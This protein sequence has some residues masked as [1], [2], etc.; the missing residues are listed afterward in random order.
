MTF[1]VRMALR[2]VRASWRRLLFFFLCIA[3]GVGSIAALRSVIQNVRAVLVAQA[4]TLLASDLLISSRQPFDDR[5]RAAIDAR[6]DAHGVEARTES[7]ET[8]TMARPADT[9]KETARMVELRGVEPQFPFYG[10]LVLE[11]G[12]PYTPALLEGHGA[13]VRPELLTQLG[14]SVGEAIVIGDTSFTVRGTIENE[15]GRRVGGFSLGPRVLVAHQALVDSGILTFGSRARYQIMAR[16]DDDAR[17]A[18][19]LERLREDFSDEFISARSYR[20][21]EDD[22]GEDLQRAENY[23]SLVGLAVVILGGIG[24]SS[25]TR[26]FVD[27][28]LKSIA[29]LKCVG[30]GTRQVIAVYLAQVMLLGLGGSLVGLLLGRA[31]L[32]VVPDRLGSAPSSFELPHTLTGPAMLQAVGIGLLVSLLFSLVPL[33]R[34]RHVRPSLLLREDTETRRR[35]DPLRWLTIVIVSGGVVALAA[36]QAASLTIGLAVCLGL[37]LL[38]LVLHLVGTALVWAARPLTRS[39]SFVLRHAVLHLTRPGSQTRVVL[40]AVGLGTFFI[41]GVRGVQHN[42]LREFAIELNDETPDLFLVDVQQDQVAGVRAMLRERTGRDPSLIPVLRARVTQVRGRDTNLE[43]IEDV[44]GRGSLAREYTVT[45]RDALERNEQIVEG[46]LW[47]P[48]P[49]PDAEVSIEQSIR[50]RFQIGL[51]DTI[52]F[53]IMGQP[54]TARVTSIRE[55]NWRDGR[56]GGFMFVFRPGVLDRAPHG[57][58]SPVRGPDDPRARARLQRDLVAA[59]PNVSAIDV[60]E[61]VEGLRQVVDNVTLG[62]T[63]VGGLVLFTGMLI[64]VGAVAMTKFRRVYE[65]AI[66]KTLGGSSRLVGAVLLTEYGLLGALAGTVGALGGLTLSWALTRFVIDMPW[67]A[68]TPWHDSAL[69]ALAS[70][71]LTAALVAIVG[72]L[73][74]LDVIRKRPLAT[75]RSE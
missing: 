55:V 15:P 65:A 74:S 29:V 9:T 64:L 48:T 58:I 52:R 73:A 46:R 7:V 59:F 57:Y 26:V 54:I 38:A 63:V 67:R 27:Q 30:A 2:E 23:L 16:L 47:P 32:V 72:L 13:L 31:A 68:D 43:G 34:V 37:A 53:D 11:G 6:F 50:D 25:V 41:L 22:V 71:L 17:L 33:L 1:V 12:D 75:L 44:R 36:W 19:L 5:T 66:L 4:R 70:I 69:E 3:I 49:S 35:R 8:A 14:I 56:R 40:L 21:M 51:G 61:I 60:R 20:T 18:A 10:T 45:Y 39:R 24:V 42:L 62:I 28:K